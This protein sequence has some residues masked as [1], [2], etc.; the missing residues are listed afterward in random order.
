MVIEQNGSVTFTTPTTSTLGR[1]K[2]FVNISCSTF[3]VISD[4]LIQLIFMLS[5][6]KNLWGIKL[7][8][9]YMP[10]HSALIS[11]QFVCCFPREAY[12]EENIR[13]VISRHVFC[14][15]SCSFFI[16]PNTFCWKIIIS[17]SSKVCLE[18]SHTILTSFQLPNRF[19]QIFSC[20]FSK[21]TAQ[22]RVIIFL[23]IDFSL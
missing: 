17:P 3:I 20:D 15:D 10:L 12:D 2:R 4:V 11:Q 22:I 1:R 7:E 8:H 6:R 18:G 9:S 19:L 13:Y 23:S 16:N 21:V 14:L 5:Q